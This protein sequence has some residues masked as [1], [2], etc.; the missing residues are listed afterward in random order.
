MLNLQKINQFYNY[1]KIIEE[2][3]KIS[4]FVSYVNNNIAKEPK[5][6]EK[7]DNPKKLKICDKPK[8]LHKEIEN[9]FPV[10]YDCLKKLRGL[11]GV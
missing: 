6:D 10:C 1:D 2:L 3:K 5:K 7:N 11:I 9:E 8:I 4:K